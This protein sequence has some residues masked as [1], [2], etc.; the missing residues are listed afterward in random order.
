MF[1][2]VLCR[3]HHTD[4]LRTRVFSRNGC[5]IKKFSIL[6]P[7]D[8]CQIN[9]KYLDQETQGLQIRFNQTFGTKLVI[10]YQPQ[11]NELQRLHN[12]KPRTIQETVHL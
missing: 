10:K 4:L 9:L 5:I 8:K 6:N 7:P 2:K 11:Q 3:Y 12:V 1:S